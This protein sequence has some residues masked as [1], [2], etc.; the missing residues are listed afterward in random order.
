M[1]TNIGK[2]KAE[3]ILELVLSLNRGNSMSSELRV[4]T[5]ER[6]YD[7]MVKRGIIKE[8]LRCR[9]VKPDTSRL[10][11]DALIASQFKHPAGPR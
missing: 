8:V 7:D 4:Q 9:K 2:T 11:T 3:I 6:Q 1:M 5:A 10:E